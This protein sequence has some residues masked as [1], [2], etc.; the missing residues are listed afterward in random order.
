M[1][2]E[3]PPRSIKN[4]EAQRDNTVHLRIPQKLKDAWKNWDLLTGTSGIFNTTLLLLK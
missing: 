3:A 4:P 2:R 1:T